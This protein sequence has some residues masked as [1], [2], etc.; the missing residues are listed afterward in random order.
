MHRKQLIFVPRLLSAITLAS[1]AGETHRVV[2]TPTVS[3][4]GTPY[5]GTKQPIVVGAFENSSPY[6]RGIFSDGQDRLGGQAKT[7]LKTHLAQTGRFILY[8]RDQS[9]ETAKEAALSGRAQQLAGAKVVLAGEVTEFGRRETGGHA[10]FG[11]LG[12]GKEQLAYS[13]VSLNVI[14]VPRSEVIFS[15]QGA[16]EYA[17]NDSEILGFGSS[18]AYDSTLN[19]K[20]L[21]LAITNAVEKLVAGMESGQWSPSEN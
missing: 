7:I 13:K 20:V 10:L 19:G 15:V 17:L 14:D 2:A 1:C 9:S 21:N 12:R 11:I 16:G 8:D 4:A 6:L 3:M 5:Q 18:S